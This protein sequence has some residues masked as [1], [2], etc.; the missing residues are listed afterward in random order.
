MLIEL[1]IIIFFLGFQKEKWMI[2]LHQDLEADGLHSHGNRPGWLIS[3]TFRLS[4][5]VIKGVVK[6]LAQST[7]PL[8][9]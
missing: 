8:T 9:I 4:Y 1:F 6:T 3:S 7:L 2:L 5:I